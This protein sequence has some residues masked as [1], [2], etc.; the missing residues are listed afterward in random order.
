MY[1]SSSIGDIVGVEE[2]FGVCV[3]IEKGCVDSMSII[4]RSV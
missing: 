4:G 1:L 3:L 2:G